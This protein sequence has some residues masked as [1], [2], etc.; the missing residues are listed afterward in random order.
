[1]ANL[2]RLQTA[3]RIVYVI[4]IVLAI[5]RVDW[6]WWGWKIEPFIF[7]WLTLPMLYQ[8]AI[9]LIGYALVVYTVLRLW[10]EP[11]NT[12]GGEE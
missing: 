11:K 1:M 6:W 3:E 7:G 10:I 4:A 5:V 9:W 2:N 12:E 8:I